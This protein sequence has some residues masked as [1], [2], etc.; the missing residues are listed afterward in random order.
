MT[1]GG[2]TKRRL[3]EYAAQVLE[4]HGAPYVTDGRNAEN[5]WRE[6]VRELRAM[7]RP[8]VPRGITKKPRSENAHL[9][10]LQ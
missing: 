4:K 2:K 9:R 8:A 5:A 3:F 7:S 10:S 6:I 1:R